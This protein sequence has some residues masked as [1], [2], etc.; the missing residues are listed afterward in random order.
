MS[1]TTYDIDSS[2]VPMPSHPDYVI[3]VIRRAT[4]AVQGTTAG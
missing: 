4:N 3:D 1:A 2:R